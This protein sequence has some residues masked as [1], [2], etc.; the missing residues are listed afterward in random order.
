M[1]TPNDVFTPGQLPIRPTNVYAHRGDPEKDFAKAL[2]R[3]LVPLIYGEFGV[4][5]T[6]MARYLAR[7]A[8]DEARLVHIESVA[9]KGLA[10]VFARILE[11][12]GYRVEKRITQSSAVTS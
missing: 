8:E 10:D 2:R 7:D 6:S 9:G 12:L 1:R 11:K 4:G 3:G 5:K